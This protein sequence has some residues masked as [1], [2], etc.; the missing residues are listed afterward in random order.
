[1]HTHSSQDEAWYVFDGGLRFK[2]AA[3]ETDLV[4][5]NDNSQPFVWAA[6]A[7]QILRGSAEVDSPSDAV[8]NYK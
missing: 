8:T 6:T 4:A 2:I 3:I 7:G 1:L 5:S